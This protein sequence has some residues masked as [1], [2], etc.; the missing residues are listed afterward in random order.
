MV[1]SNL[2][3]RDEAGGN[4]YDPHLFVEWCHLGVPDL[5]MRM[6]GT[7]MNCQMTLNNLLL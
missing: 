1:N 4:A 7:T 2:T 3:A 5:R 6:Q